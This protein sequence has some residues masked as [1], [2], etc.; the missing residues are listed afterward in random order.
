MGDLNSSIISF[1]NSTQNIKTI[2]ALDNEFERVVGSF[3]IN[4]FSCTEITRP[5][6]PVMPRP[7]FGRLRPD[8]MLHYSNR[9]YGQIDPALHST[10][11]RTN[12]FQWSDIQNIHDRDI[13]RLFGEAKDALGE[14]GI[15]VPIHGP[16]GQIHVVIMN[17]DK[18]E[19]APD[20]LPALR[21]AAMYY[22]EVGIEL[23]E[24]NEHIACQNALSVRQIDCLNW[25][26]EGKSDWE[27]GEILGISE[28]TVHRHIENA[29]KLLG[30]ST[31]MQSVVHCLRS[32]TIIPG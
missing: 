12:A 26:A 21:L 2:V 23:H 8:W 3:G 22:A 20:T 1:I 13:S 5:G 16:R 25:A 19:K 9:N 17:G 32:R 11:A 31:R 29:K 27:I 30:V 15:V 4:I 14:E 10:I 24:A 6:S 7:L 28:N 18:V